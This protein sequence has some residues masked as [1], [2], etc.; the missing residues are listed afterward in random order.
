MHDDTK[1][2]P[3]KSST[4]DHDC[5][6][7]SIKHGSPLLFCDIGTKVFCISV[8]TTCNTSFITHLYAQN[9]IKPHRYRS[10]CISVPTTCNTLFI[11]HL[12]A[13]NTI[14]PNNF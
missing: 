6:A 8:P 10:Y 12:Y 11:T 4:S 9:T 13:Q 5:Y 14:K 3:Y 2:S 1:A 7:L